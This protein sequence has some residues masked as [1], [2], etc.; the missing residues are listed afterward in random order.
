MAARTADRRAGSR[1][2]KV[3]VGEG[4]PRERER[5]REL[6]SSEKSLPPTLSCFIVPLRPPPPT[7]PIAAIAAVRLSDEAT[8]FLQTSTSSQAY[9]SDAALGLL[10]G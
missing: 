7:V 10:E 4:E 5:E 6:A 1:S 8:T 9:E 2:T 3:G